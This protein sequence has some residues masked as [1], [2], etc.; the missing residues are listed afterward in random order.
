MMRNLLEAQTDPTNIALICL[1]DDWVERFLNVRTNGCCVCYC[2]SN[3][4]DLL[5]DVLFLCSEV[6]VVWK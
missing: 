2:L 3:V 4:A 5:Y 6:K 1:S